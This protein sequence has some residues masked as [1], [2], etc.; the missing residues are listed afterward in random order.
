[1]AILDEI[2]QMQ[3]DGKSD[4]EISMFMQQR[5]FSG[6]DAA[7][8]IAQARIKQ[9][10]SDSSDSSMVSSYPT[11]TQDLQ[12][13]IISSGNTDQ[14]QSEMPSNQSANQTA[15]DPQGQQY[16][17]YAQQP[18]QQQP[19]Q[20]EYAAPDNTGYQQQYQQQYQ[21]Y[22]PYDSGT[23]TDVISEIA[24]QV[25]AEKMVSLRR[26][27][28]SIIDLKTSMEAKL[29]GVDDRLKRIEK[30]IDRLQLSILQKVGEYVTNVEDIKKEMTETQKS[31]KAMSNQSNQ[32]SKVQYKEIE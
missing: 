19:Q 6:R 14:N 17:Q 9:A 10:V 11:R 20:Q 25:M 18:Q 1:M 23:S 4:D 32:N 8:A 5:G 13:S 7:D 26:Q 22:S 16:P 21:E 2:K 30:V 29:A 12:Q 24:E 3:A 31:F 28:E 15:A 27:L